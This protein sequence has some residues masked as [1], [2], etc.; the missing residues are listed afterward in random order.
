M[1]VGRTLRVPL[2][3]YRVTG[4]GSPL[5]RAVLS[6]AVR[7][8]SGRFEPVQFRVDTG[9]GVTCLSVSQPAELGIPFVRKP[10]TFGLE[11][12]T[13]KVRQARHLGHLRVRIPGL[14]ARAFQWPCH[15][16]EHEGV[17][18]Q[19]VLGLSGVLDDLIISL[20]GRYASGAPYGWLILTE[21]PVH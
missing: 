14:G 10:V 11:T 16:V 1:V 5:V 9:A 13:G 6:L 4:M 12:A 15:F 2:Q 7:L 18:P 19:A 21:V 8:Q 17:P 3:P 20:D